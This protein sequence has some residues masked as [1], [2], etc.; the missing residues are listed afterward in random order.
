MWKLGEAS[1]E[2]VSK[3]ADANELDT[4]KE[5]AI[6]AQHHIDGAL[7]STRLLRAISECPGHKT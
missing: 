1:Y 3:E 4:S 2:E 5:R 6:S 7:I